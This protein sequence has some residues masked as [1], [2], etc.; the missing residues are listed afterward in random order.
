MDRIWHLCTLAVFTDVTFSTTARLF[1]VFY[2]APAI[3]TRVLIADAHFCLIKEKHTCI[4]ID[5]LVLTYFSCVLHTR[6]SNRQFAWQPCWMAETLEHFCMKKTFHFPD[7]KK[8]VFFLSSNVTTMQTIYTF[9]KVSLDFYAV[10]TT[11]LV[12][13]TSEDAIN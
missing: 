4:M 6:R 10:S 13:F 12:L 7:E 8:K 5:S 11:P 1:G 9:T 2:A 3:V